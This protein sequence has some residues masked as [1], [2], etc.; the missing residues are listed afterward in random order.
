MLIDPLKASR[1]G[2]ILEDSFSLSRFP[3]F[4]SCLAES[5][6]TVD[7]KL[8]FFEDKAHG[9][10]ATLWLKGP[11]ALICQGC[12]EK[13]PYDLLEKVDF[14]WAATEK[15]AA[16]LP[17][18]VLPLSVNESGLLDVDEML[19]DALILALP[20][21]PRHEKKD[22]SLK[23]NRAYYASPREEVHHTYKPFT[24]LEELVQ[25][26]EKKSGGPAK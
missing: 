18:E 20:A 15:E 24:N 7:V 13:M 25:L 14:Q 8:A 1:E 23:K 16:A 11:V 4:L 26:K 6:G 5:A 22:C 2:L 21:F 10:H 19:E 3:R 9:V 17:L 12:N